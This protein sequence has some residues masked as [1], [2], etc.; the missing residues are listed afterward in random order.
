MS[1]LVLQPAPA[2]EGLANAS[3][4]FE[5][6]QAVLH[7][8]DP[9]REAERIASRL[10]PGLEWTVV[11]GAGLGYLVE[12]LLRA[13]PGK[14]ILFEHT[15][16]I[17]DYARSV[18]P[19]DTA[20]SDPRV[21]VFDDPNRLLE[22]LEDNRIR[23]LNFTVHR[24]YQTLFPEVYSSLEGLIAAYL[25]RRNINDATL[26]RF[27]KVWLRNILK[28]APAYFTTPGIRHIRHSFAGKPAVVVGAGP[29]LAKNLAALR[30]AA[31][32][33]VVIAADTALPMLQYRGIAA[34]FVVSVD[35]QNKNTLF[36]LYA[37]QSGTS[38]TRLVMDA[39]ASFLSLAK[40][41]SAGTYLS[42]SIFPVYGILQNF[43]GEKG[44]LAAGGSVSTAAFDL[45]RQFGC[46]PIILAGQD[47]AYSGRQTHAHG[48]VLEE[49]LYYR[50]GRLSTYDN[51]NTR[52]LLFSDRF[53]VDGWSGGKVATDRKFTTFLEWFVREIRETPARVVN[54]TEGGA[55]I[56]GAEHI[57]LSEAATKYCATKLDK[58]VK[59]GY[60]PEARGEAD[61]FLG[62]LSALCETWIPMAAKAL[63]AA[64]KCLGMYGSGKD[65][66]G[67][68]APM[69]EFDTA[70]LQNVRSGKPA[71]RFIEFVMQNSI[72]AILDSSNSE[73]LDEATIKN[74]IRIYSEAGDA[75]QSIRRLL[76]KYRKLAATN[77]GRR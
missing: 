57:S 13:R 25:S 51:Y 55:R 41:E 22:F 68:F 74:W 61:E 11:C 38:A 47:L 4:T 62:K 23:E 50:I 8:R 32:G 77:G 16:E 3:V 54:A 33:A 31:S 19:V 29:S 69:N 17:L 12:H 26:K 20:L 65:I 40:F 5:G 75:L 70:V 73:G 52:S 44:R 39:A 37:N 9:Q 42:D 21:K 67:Q 7:S 53:A 45:A 27:Q 30:D 49:F 43:F 64:R 10:N 6:R 60:E 72:Q 63:E 35:P 46:D 2:V 71:A 59:T 15:P 24:P 58:S 14:V 48:N 34:D 36:L 56:E 18:R 66:R 1:N 28:N 76:G